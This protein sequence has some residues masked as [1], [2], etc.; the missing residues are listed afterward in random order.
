MKKLKRT[1][2]LWIAVMLCMA[3][4]LTAFADGETTAVS[5]ANDR[6]TETDGS[7]TVNSPV[8]G[9]TYT[10]YRIF[11]ADVG[12]NDAIT[13]NNGGQPLADNVYF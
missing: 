7:I 13:Y 3:M 6:N 8:P 12:Q 1:A 5:P 4:S 2:A 11:K 10:L 9:Q